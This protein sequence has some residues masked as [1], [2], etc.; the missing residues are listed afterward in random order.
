MTDINQPT[1]L[2][3]KAEYLREPISA[4]GIMLFIAWTLLLV[5][6]LYLNLTNLREEVVSLATTEAKANW[7]KD[8]AFRGWATRHGGIYVTPNERTPPS[9]YLAH[10]PDR[11]L[12]TTD[13]QQL[14]LMNPAYMMRQMTQEYEQIYGVKGSITGKILLN[15]INAPDEWEL[16]VL[17]SF[18]LGAKEVVEEINID[19]DPYIRYM[20]PMVMV[21][22]C[23]KCHGHL[24]FKV[25]DIRG[26][27]SVS[28]PLNPYI[29]GS[30]TTSKQI[31]T[32][33]GFVWLFGCFGIT[34]FSWFARRRD[35]E[36]YLLQQELTQNQ[37]M[38]EQRV[39][40]RTQELKAKEKELIDS[41][42]RAHYANKM[43]SLGEMASGMA[44][45]INS[46]LQSIALTAFRL[47]R[48]V[49]NT[50]VSESMEKVDNAVTQIT[51]IIESLSNVSRDSADDDFVTEPIKNIILDVAG[52]TTER[53]KTKSIEFDIC[54][55]GDSEKSSLS[56]QRLQIS[57][58]L[59]N[60]LNNAF[61]AAS[62]SNDKWIRLDIYD[63]GETIV[64][65]VTDSGAGV[66]VEI[67][68]RIFEPLYTSKDI[69]E[70]TGLGLSISSDIA[71]KHG[72]TLELD[73][74]SP[75][76]RFVLCLPKSQ[77]I[78]EKQD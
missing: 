15:P 52:I 10:I 11:D 25:G 18:E 62:E 54:Y 24:G 14:T 47:K 69:G 7:S 36:R 71:K 6:S 3:D 78:N 2:E 73:T 20:K 77:P 45:E 67:R 37:V 4:I 22:G 8:Q 61:Y 72:G 63:T 29:Q 46:P 16:K 64:I 43:A 76:T 19:G 26:G 53:Y 34:G 60:L 75:D 1:S 13:G 27:V 9:P 59:I 74:Q 57:Q 32:S 42:T 31:T 58:I 12:V 44:H 55:H 56:C 65:S 49:D 30:V 41:H 33:H 50:E 66:P 40:E 35:T 68:D 70:G 28:I 21:E 48:N 23:V 39:K 38:L 17:D 5:L 51:Q